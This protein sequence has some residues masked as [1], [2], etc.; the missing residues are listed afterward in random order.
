[1]HISRSV[2]LLFVIS[3]FC[4]CRVFRGI[5]QWKCDKLGMCYFG[6]TPSNYYGSPRLSAP[7][8]RIAFPTQGLVMPAMTSGCSQCQK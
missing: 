7:Q 2:F 3:S 1:M 8:P 4:G 5:E 6:T